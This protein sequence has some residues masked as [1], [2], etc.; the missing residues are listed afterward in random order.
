MCVTYRALTAQDAFEYRQLRLQSLQQAPSCYGAS[1]AEQVALST[2]YVESLI[3]QESD[4]VIML[5]AFMKAELVALCG[6]KANDDN[7]R[8]IIQMYVAPKA[9]GKAVA[10]SLLHLAKKI[11]KARA[12]NGLILTVYKE[13]KRA[14]A[15]YQKAGFGVLNSQG[16]EII[17]GFHMI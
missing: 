7:Q 15:S 10:Q 3:E 9:R 12:T 1:Y 17:M 14:I 4:E 8:E 6:L 11:G 13:N 2:L 16:K 5:G